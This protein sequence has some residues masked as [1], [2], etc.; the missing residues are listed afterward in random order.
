MIEIVMQEAAD[1]PA[2]GWLLVGLAGFWVFLVITQRFY[3]YWPDARRADPRELALPRMQEYE[4]KA[5]GRPRLIVWGAEP[6][7]KGGPVVVYLHGNAR[8]LAAR[9]RFFSYFL[10]AGF[11]FAALSH[12]GFGG[13]RGHP[14][15]KNNVADAVALIDA[16]VERGVALERIVVFGESLGTGTAVQAAM[17]RKVGGLILQAPMDALDRLASAKT[18]YFVPP[19][20]VGE[21][22]RSIDHI[23]KVECPLLWLH[24][25]K[26]R[27]IPAWRGRRLYEKHP[28]PKY[29]APVRDA[30]HFGLYRRWIFNAHIRFFI[31]A[32]ACGAHREPIARA[33]S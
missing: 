28:G 21:R 2:W 16:L 31:E 18:F 14:S 24:G 1:L 19:L 7:E 12:R 9:K 30:N 3:F 20:V 6:L 15:E 27:V 11:G 10:R 4:F 5:K 13:S 23:D 26:D 29:Y 25:D 17:H 22:Y 32:V 33:D 8:A